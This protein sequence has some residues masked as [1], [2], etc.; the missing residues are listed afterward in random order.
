MRRVTAM[1]WYGSQVIEGASVEGVF[2]ECPRCGIR[3]F[4][5]GTDT[6]APARCLKRLSLLCPRAEGNTY[7]TEALP[8]FESIP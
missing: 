4:G 7:T 5:R 1:Y 6:G 2:A 3:V 8:A